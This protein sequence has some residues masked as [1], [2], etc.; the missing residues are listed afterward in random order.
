MMSL[1][2]RFVAGLTITG[3]WLG[4]LVGFFIVLPITLVVRHFSEKEGMSASHTTI[5]DDSL[6]DKR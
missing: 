1:M 4:F 5:S 6:S 2:L 3:V